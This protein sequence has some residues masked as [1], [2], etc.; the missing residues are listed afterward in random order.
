VRAGRRFRK[1]FKQVRERNE[2]IDLEYMNI[3]ALH[4]LGDAVRKTLG[5]YA[6]RLSEGKSI[7]MAPPRR[8]RVRSRGVE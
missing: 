4:S 5:Q 3:G 7:T 8:G 6:A 2:A 1:V